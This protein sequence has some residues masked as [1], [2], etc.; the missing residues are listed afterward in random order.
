MIRSSVDLP[1]PDG[2]TRAVTVPGRSVSADV[3]ERHDRCATGAAELLADA[4][5]GD[6]GRGGVVAIIRSSGSR[7]P[8]CDR[9][10]VGEDLLEQGPVEQLGGGAGDA[11]VGEQLHVVGDELVGE[12]GEAVRRR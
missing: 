2:P 6:R 10:P 7:R 3:V 4:G 12:P 11:E 5:A 8:S 9:R 1:Q